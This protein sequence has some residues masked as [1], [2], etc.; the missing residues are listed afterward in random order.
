M[1]VRG[2]VAQRLLSAARPFHFNCRCGFIRAE[3]ERQRQVTGG[4]VAGSAV[5]GLPLRSAIAGDSH[6]G[7]DTIAIALGALQRDAQP[8]ILIPGIVLVQICRTAI[9]RH[10]YIQVPVQIVIAVR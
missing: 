7:S 2:N 10:Q 4:T 3:P 6:H 8:V 9:R 1:L 5:H